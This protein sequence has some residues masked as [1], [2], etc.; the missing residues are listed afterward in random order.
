MPAILIV[1]LSL[2]VFV[3]VYL[4]VF[5]FV[6]ARAATRRN[7][8]RDWNFDPASDNADTFSPS[9]D[10]PFRTCARDYNIWWNSMPLERY[11]TVSHDGLRLVGHLL[12]AREDTRRVAFVLHGHR[13][14]SGEMGFISKMYYDMGY[15][16]FAPDQRAHGKSEGTYIGMGY[17]ECRD[18][19]RWLPVVTGL[20]GDGCEIV[21]HGISMG[22]ATAMTT[23]GEPALPGNVVCA[24]ED[25]GYTDAYASVYHHIAH[26]MKWVPLK[27]AVVS[28][29][30]AVN[31]WKAGFYFRQADCIAALQK[32]SVPMLFIHGTHD[33]VV[34][35]RMLTDLYDAHPGEKD[36]LVVA[37]APHGICYFWDTAGYT[38][39]TKRFLEKYMAP[40]C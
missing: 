34:P 16:V 13:C 28:A 21:L 31:R 7:E 22:A 19:L 38:E 40:L 24:I 3:V 2:V 4:V 32:T 25:C 36:M 8:S 20:I 12:R 14:V 35:F 27:H 39:K 26:D 9:G 37:G 30:S 11:E 29:A 15:H 17:F 5:A 18:M 23:A 10:S 6:A 33:P 1:A